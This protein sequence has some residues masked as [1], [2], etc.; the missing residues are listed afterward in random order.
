MNLDFSY[1]LNPLHIAIKD[2]LCF[3]LL[4]PL[5]DI[6]YDYV[7]YLKWIFATYK[8]FLSYDPVN[9]KIISKVELPLSFHYTIDQPIGIGDYVY[10]RST[11]NSNSFFQCDANQSSTI[12]YSPLPWPTCPTPLDWRVTPS[13]E[14]LV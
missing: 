7:G 12:K 10:W 11:V 2:A 3:K 14:R 5:V 1:R 9:N 4:D 8:T 13:K 6:A